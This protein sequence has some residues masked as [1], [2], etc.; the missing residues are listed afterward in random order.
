MKIGESKNNWLWDIILFVIIILSFHFL[1]LIT[2]PFLNTV[3]FYN[4]VLIKLTNLVFLESSWL[5]DTFL[6]DITIEGRKAIFENSRYIIVSSGCSGLKP[7]MQL[8]VLFV[9]FPG[10]FIK[11][12]WFIPLGILLL[13]IVNILRIVSLAVIIMEYPRVW[14]FAHDWIFRPFFYVVIFSLWWYWNDK[15]RKKHQM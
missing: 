13:H 10:P 3:E 4:A 11:K 14:E 7:T 1:Y 8:I 15:I 6:Y 9:F 2:L 12:L 5:I